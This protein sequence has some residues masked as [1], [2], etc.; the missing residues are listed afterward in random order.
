LIILPGRFFY[1][2]SAENSP[3]IGGEMNAILVP[4]QWVSKHLL[5]K[6]KSLRRMSRI[7]KGMNCGGTIQNP[8]AI[9]PRRNL[10]LFE[11]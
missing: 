10:L 2:Y 1:L 3:S 5:N 11:E 4:F 9:T 6:D 7:F 8:D